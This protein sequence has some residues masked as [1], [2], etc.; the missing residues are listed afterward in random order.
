MSSEGNAIPPSLPVQAAHAAIPVR[1]ALPWMFAAGVYLLLLLLGAKLLND[2]DSYWHIAVA[3]WI[4]EH[5]AFPT[6]DPF[7]HTMPGAHWIAFEWL[8]EMV[9]AG[10]HAVAGWPG[11]IVVA[12]AAIALAFAILMHFLLQRLD[13]VPALIM[14]LAAVVLT[15]PHML[16]RPHALVLP[17]MV[18][19]VGALVGAVERRTAPPFVFLPLIALWA[20]LHGSVAIGVAFIAPAAIE[21]LLQTPRAAWRKTA[22][23][24]FLF[25]MLA[26][27]AA[28]LTPYGPGILLAPINTLSL[29]SALS[30]IGEWKP[31]D[32]GKLGAFEVVLLLGVGFAL[33]RGLTLP[34][35]RILVVLGLLHLALSQSRHAD[36][37]A[38]LAPL[39]LAQPLAAQL[40]RRAV[41]D[42][43]TATPRFIFAALAVVTFAATAFALLR[44]VAPAAR[45]TPAAAVTATGLAK[46][47]PLF[48]DYIFGGYLIYAGIAPFID[49]RGEI[50]GRKLMLRH[51]NAITLQNVPDLLRLLDEYRI[52]ATLLTPATPAVALLDRLPDWQ[53]VYADE[54]TVVHKRRNAA[55]P[56]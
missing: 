10:A 9:Y 56:R 50:Y 25:A 27:V 8:S 52:A 43:D 15:A 32:F 40:N 21:A 37:L 41:T 51:H 28:S 30:I 17:V 39:Y 42:A 46:A 35:V 26:V 7:S 12:A 4:L 44:D 20:N 38:L 13:T 54:I 55:E 34:P 36:L 49:G 22:Q 31:Q 16:A 33:L 18:A 6:G 2:P 29:G 47:G 3:R 5:S 14:G 23:Q 53:R 11:V 1:A 19:W 48:N 24:W 45:N